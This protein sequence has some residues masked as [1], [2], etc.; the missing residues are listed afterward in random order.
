MGNSQLSPVDNSTPYHAQGPTAPVTV[1]YPC[2]GTQNGENALFYTRFRHCAVG[3]ASHDLFAFYPVVFFFPHARGVYRRS[4]PIGS[5]P[6][7]KVAR[8]KANKS[9]LSP[10]TSQGGN[11]T[12]PKDRSHHGTPKDILNRVLSNILYGVRDVSDTIP[13]GRTHL[14]HAPSHCASHYTQSKHLQCSQR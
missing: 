8:W 11:S 6:F 5:H 9:W 10:T 2:K 7:I 3:L 14:T 1:L 12:V 4:D 13:I